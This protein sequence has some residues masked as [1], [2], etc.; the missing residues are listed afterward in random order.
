M[1]VERTNDAAV[2]LYTKAGY[3]QQPEDAAARGFAAALRLTHRD[4][5]LMFK[6][7]C[8][9]ESGESKDRA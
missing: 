5:L 4:P 1:H 2:A 8:R 7:L 6:A 3:V 9:H